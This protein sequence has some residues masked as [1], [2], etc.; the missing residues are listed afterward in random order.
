LTGQG[1][2]DNPVA[3]GVPAPDAPISHATSAYSATINGQNANVFFLGL[4]PGYVGLAQ[5]NIT[6]PSSL[7]SGDYP[8]IITVNGVQSNGPLITVSAPTAP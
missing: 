1:P 7:A 4:A 8:L 6:V 3:D 2:V 5:A